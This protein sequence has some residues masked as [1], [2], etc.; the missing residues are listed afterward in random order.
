MTKQMNT[1]KASTM[2]DTERLDWVIKHKATCAT[3]SRMK[4]RAGGLHESNLETVYCLDWYQ[5]NG[6]NIEHTP[7]C[8]Y[9][10]VRE[11]IDGAMGLPPNAELTHGENNP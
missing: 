5:P 9:R 10:T 2:T 1:V 4:T 6:D 7:D 11:A 3:R 8:E